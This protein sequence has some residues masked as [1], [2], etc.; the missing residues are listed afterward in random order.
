MRLTIPAL[1]ALAILTAC[2]SNG[3]SSAASRTAA[4][5]S[6]SDVVDGITIP[7]PYVA[8]AGTVVP[9]PNI[10]PADFATTLDAAARGGTFAM[11]SERSAHLIT[12]QYENRQAAHRNCSK[13]TIRI[14]TEPQAF[15]AFNRWTVETGQNSMWSHNPKLRP[16]PVAGIGVEA[17]WVPALLELGAGNPT[18]WVSV[19]LNCPGS[20]PSVL[21]LA[22]MLAK[23]G[24]ASTA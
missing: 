4:V 7:P 2:S 1:A 17:E 8:P 10:C 5:P 23:E 16:T 24:L 13:S 18:T 20:T 14:N 9:G 19:I 6:N 15:V 11:T 21:A 12:C 3:S 22:K